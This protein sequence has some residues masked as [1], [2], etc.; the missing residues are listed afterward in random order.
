M[1]GRKSADEKFPDEKMPD[2]KMSGHV[3]FIIQ[4]LAK[5]ESCDTAYVLNVAKRDHCSRLKIC[6]S[7]V[8][9]DDK[10]HRETQD[11]GSP[12]I[13]GLFRGVLVLRLAQK[14]KRTVTIRLCG[15]LPGPS[16]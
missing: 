11:P 10:F 16:R 15:R 1:S 12:K 8:N 3:K 9:L 13:L 14:R 2:E 4:I 6:V 7:L 5:L